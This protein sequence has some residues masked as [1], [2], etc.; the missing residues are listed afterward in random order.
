MVIKN[1]NKKHDVG[2]KKG[3]HWW[4]YKDKHCKSLKKMVIKNY[5]CWSFTNESVR[6]LF[7][8]SLLNNNNNNN[9]SEKMVK[10]RSVKHW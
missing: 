7:K 1:F 2:I 8:L 3:W 10:K 5:K 4:M 9:K 6:I